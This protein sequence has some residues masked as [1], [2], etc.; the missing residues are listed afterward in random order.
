[1][2]GEGLVD[3]VAHGVAQLRLG[4]APVQGQCGDEVD[5]VDARLGRQVEHRLDDPLADVGAPHGRQRQRDVVEADRELH[6]RV[7]ASPERRTAP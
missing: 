2:R 1:V 6:A 7:E 3:P 5:V 4:H